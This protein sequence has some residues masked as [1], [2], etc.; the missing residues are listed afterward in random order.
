MLSPHRVIFDMYHT[1]LKI[2]IYLVLI[3]QYNFLFNNFSIA[4]S[5][6]KFEMIIY[7]IK[8]DQSLI[9]FSY[10]LSVALNLSYQIQNK[11]PILYAKT[12]TFFN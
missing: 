9:I 5:L 7:A 8:F 3:V 4:N 2:Y 11:I 1:L 6:T 12:T 10:F